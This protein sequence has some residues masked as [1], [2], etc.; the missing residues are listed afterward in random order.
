MELKPDAIKPLNRLLPWLLLCLVAI[1]AY[2]NALPNTLV[3]DDRLFAATALWQQESDLARLFTENVWAAAGAVENLYRPLFL[4]SVSLDARL[5]G[6]NYTAWHAVNLGLHVLVTLLVFVLTRRLLT[7]FYGHPDQALLLALMAGLL[8]AVHPV[9][10]EVV[11]SI[12]NRSELMASAFVLCGAVWLLR[13]ID[14][15]VIVAW[16]GALVMYSLALF[17]RETAIVMPGMLAVLAWCWTDGPARKRLLQCLPVLLM[18]IPMLLYLKAREYAI[19][20]PVMEAAGSASPARPSARILRPEQLFDI[21]RILVVAGVWLQ[22]IK[23]MVWPHPLKLAH[24]NPTDV[25]RVIGLLVHVGLVSLSLV[26][27]WRRRFGLLIALAIFYLGLLPSSRLFGSSEYP[28]L[29]ERY[30][31]LPSVGFCLYIGFA[32]RP[33]LQRTDW[34]MTAAPVLLACILMFP[35]T[36][37]RNQLWGDDLTLTETDYKNGVTRGDFLRHLTGLQLMHGEYQRVVEVCD[38]HSNKRGAPGMLHSHCGTAYR[39]VGRNDEAVAAYQRAT[40]TTYSAARAHSNLAG[41]FLK[42]GQRDLASHHFRE[43]VKTEQNE[44]MK[45]YREGNLLYALY[46]SN[47]NQLQKAI[48]FYDEAL[49]IQPKLAIAAQRKLRAEKQLARLQN[50]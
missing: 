6:E 49:T 19:E 22:G 23:M 12:F 45:K 5:F 9:H 43:A 15:R 4:V 31:Y 40:K 17:S 33:L 36:W 11:N 32:L 7:R 39:A 21:K 38:K 50:Q 47:P 18:I 14:S 1:A 16:A 29:T 13:F 24:S 42:Q 26:L 30:L 46:P 20:G 28:H 8:F 27:A 2:A 41:H 25:V 48:E 37:S 35:L 34:K 3:M 10:T 44:A